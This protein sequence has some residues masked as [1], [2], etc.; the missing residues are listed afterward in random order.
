M[1]INES[2]PTFSTL[3][4]FMTAPHPPAP[5]VNNGTITHFV[6]AS[7][8]N[9]LQQ[10]CVTES[11]VASARS[12]AQGIKVY[13]DN[14]QQQF[15]GALT[16]SDLASLAVTCHHNQ[17]QLKFQQQSE[18]RKLYVDIVYKEKKIENKASDK[19]KDR[20]EYWLKA[21]DTECQESLT[22]AFNAV[23]Q[24]CGAFLASRIF[25]WAYQAR[26]KGFH[27]IMGEIWQVSQ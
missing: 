18:D 27:G 9:R 14:L 17:E 12:S 1:G 8:T 20:A 15:G 4:P 6:P 19:Q 10:I 5:F 7:P 23:P 25:V 2:P 11:T 3:T 21:L 26:Q 22:K 13:Y 16:P 24:S